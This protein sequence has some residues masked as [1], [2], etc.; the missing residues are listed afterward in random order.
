MATSNNLV[1]TFI[2]QAQAQKEVTA[3]AAFSRI[4]AILNRGAVDKDLATPP[5]SPAAGDL[6]IVAAAATGAWS[7][8]SGQVAYYDQ[9]WRFI[10]P[11][12][13]MTLWVNDEDKHYIYNGTG[14]QTALL[15]FHQS[16]LIETVANKNYTLILDVPYPILI[17]QTVVQSASGTCTGTFKINTTSLGGGAHSV[18]TTKT[19][20]THGSANSAIA[21]DSLILTVSSNSSCLDLAYRITY[22]RLI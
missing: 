2:E 16:G 5:G 10:V 1:L 15:T 20:V 19:T 22:L 6:Y 7:G 17:A 8:K 9:I 21:G 18:S 11:K 12:E 4:D 14:W 3:N 13:G